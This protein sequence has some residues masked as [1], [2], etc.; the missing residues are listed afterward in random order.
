MQIEV[1][2]LSCVYSQKTPFEKRALDG[3]SF[4]VEAGQS[5]GVARPLAN[6]GA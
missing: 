3:V 2:D 1:K 4:S 6:F 5:V